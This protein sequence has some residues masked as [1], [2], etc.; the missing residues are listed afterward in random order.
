[1]SRI[2]RYLLFVT[3]VC[4][5]VGCAHSPAP[6]AATK[7][8]FLLH[9]P[10]TADNAAPENKLAAQSQPILVLPEVTLAPYLRF[11][12]IIYQAG[13]NRIVEA[14][15]N[16]WA[17]PLD[18]QTTQGLHAALDQGLH[19]IDVRRP[20]FAEKPDYR[21]FVYIERFQGRYDG[22]AV[23]S[24]QWRLFGQNEK[25]VGRGD[26]AQKTP[27]K[28]DGYP[29]LVRALSRGWHTIKQNMVEAITGLVGNTTR[30][31]ENK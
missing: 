14:D 18:T 23:I 2:S 29:A 11:D 30:T 13:P 15:S 5:L 31:S 7:G 3:L 19:G 16:N 8:M 27:M 6:S 17:A 4:L 9:Q 22:M 21:L 25:L 1:M 10:N 26:F 28:N 20:E 24:G 12:G